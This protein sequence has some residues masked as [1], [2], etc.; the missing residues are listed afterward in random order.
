[1]TKVNI[2]PSMLTQAYRAA[3]EV[4][5]ILG[6][7][8]GIDQLAQI[9]E[10]LDGKQETQTKAE[11]VAKPKSVSQQKKSSAR[12]LDGRKARYKTQS[13]HSGDIYIKMNYSNTGRQL[14]WNHL[15]TDTLLDGE[16]HSVFIPTSMT[17]ALKSLE[18]YLRHSASKAGF[19]LKFTKLGVNR[20]T[21]QLLEMRPMGTRHPKYI[22]KVNG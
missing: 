5:N 6:R 22:A 19:G 21:V 9:V 4:G 2:S 10:L 16:E 3:E 18:S 20:G 8:V 12:K 13:Q 11:V 14:T 15:P 1:M 7:K 17:T